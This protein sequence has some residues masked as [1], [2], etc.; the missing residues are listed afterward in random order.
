MILIFY[1][2]LFAGEIRSQLPFMLLLIGSSFTWAIGSL[3]Q[4]TTRDENPIPFF[5]NLSIQIFSGG[6]SLLFISYLAGET[7][8][9]IS[10]LE[11]LPTL[12]MIYLALVGT[13]IAYTCYIYCLRNAPAALVSTYALVNPVIA[14]LLGV[15]FLGEAFSMRLAYASALVLSG[16]AIVIFEPFIKGTFRKIK[17][18]RKSKKQM[19]C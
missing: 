17:V 4:K 7:I 2:A 3:L 8:P 15:L 11:L 14:I 12:A 10:D 16:V 18:H 5:Q 19:V 1:P 9:N 6:V 13:V